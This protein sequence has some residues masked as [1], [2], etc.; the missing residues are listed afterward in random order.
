[1]RSI[2][3]RFKKF[4]KQNLLLADYA[5]L[6]LAVLG[7][8]YTK[9]TLSTYFDLLVPIADYDGKERMELLED[10]YQATTKFIPRT[11]KNR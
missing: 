2:E 9:R 10:L 3:R 8:R 11:D 7:Q 6:R 4:S 1:M 5:N